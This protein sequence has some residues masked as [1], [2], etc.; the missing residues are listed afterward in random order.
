MSGL[1]GR[2]VTLDGL[3]KRVRE[4]ENSWI[5][6]S[7]GTRLAARVWRP[8]DAEQAPVPA[9]LEYLPY[10]KRDITAVSDSMMHPYFAAHGYASV[11]VDIRGSGDSDGLLMGEYLRQEQDD[12]LEVIAWLADQPWCNGAVGMIGISWGGFNG[13]QLAARQPPSLKAIITLCSTDDR[14]SDDVHFMGGALLT[15]NLRWG[16]TLHAFAV[17]PPDPA[18]VGERWRSMWLQ[19]LNHVPFFAAEWLRHQRRDSFWAHGSVCGDY[20]AIRCAVY[21]IG[22]WVDGYSNA[23]SRLLANLTCPRKGLIGPWGHQLPMVAVPGPQIGFLQE[24]LR[25]WDA[26]LK[27]VNTG[28]MDEPML[29]VWMQD[30]LRPSALHR[31]TPGRWIAESSWPSLLIGAQ[32]FYLIPGRLADNPGPEVPLLL[33]SPE[34]LG[35]LGGIW[36]PYD[37]FADEPS[38]QRDEDAKSLCFDTSPLPDRI[39]ILGAPILELEVVS[40]RPSAK[41]VARLCD[42]HPDGASTRVTYGILNLTHR[43][44]H[45][46]PRPLNLSQRYRARIKLNDTAYSFPPGHRIRVALSNTY[47]PMTWPSPERV[48]LTIVTGTGYICLPVRTPQAEDAGLAA[49]PQPEVALA[50]PHTV[51]RP[52]VGY[53]TVCRE[54]GSSETVSTVFDDHGQVRLQATGIEMASTRHTEYRIRDDDPLS[55]RMASKWSIDIGRGDWRTRTVVRSFMTATPDSFKLRAELDAF[56]DDMR[57]CSRNWDQI[58]RR[59]LT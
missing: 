39:E 4:I 19:R 6:L 56:Q 28:I 30:G 48:V 59:D 52:G 34:S 53:R 36:C 7:D 31:D 51:L 8:D 13:L 55:A 20:A 14:Y 23:V 17:R 24:A 2:T 40:D 58:V 43:D 21:A 32:R 42:V 54:L 22:G 29:R 10:R 49:Y 5:P 38:D 9:I 15:D 46:S 27:G 50:E 3:P 47:W 25:W 11:R 12:C 1:P 26:W 57:I 18:L 41:L 44:D 37:I 33:S 35:T 16:T 45:A